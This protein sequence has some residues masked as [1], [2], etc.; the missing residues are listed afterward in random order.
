A[1]PGGEALYTRVLQARGAKILRLTG[2]DRQAVMACINAV[3][4]GDTGEAPRAE[5]RRLAGALIAAG[6][7][8]V[9]AGCTEVPLLLGADDV[10]VPLVDSAEVLAAACVRACA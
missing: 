2:S 9:I 6:A 1:T 7:E 4:A 5:M 10:S 8:V 3:K